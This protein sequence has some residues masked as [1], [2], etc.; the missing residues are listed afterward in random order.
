MKTR[1]ATPA[2]IQ[3]RGFTALEQALNPVEYVRF[4][5]Q[6]MPGRG[7]YT[8]QRAHRTDKLTLSEIRKGITKMQSKAK[9]A[10]TLPPPK[11]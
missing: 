7:D 2:E 6:I 9:R 10:R 1:Q 8:R 11:I 5:Q 3:V 4:L